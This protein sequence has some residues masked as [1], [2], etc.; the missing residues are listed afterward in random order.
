MPYRLL[1]VIVAIALILML[2]LGFWLSARLFI[3]RYGP[4][5]NAMAPDQVRRLTAWGFA[6]FGIGLIGVGIGG[7]V[8]ASLAFAYMGRQLAD[9]SWATGIVWGA[10]TS[11]LNAAIVGGLLVALVLNQ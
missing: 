2:L 3:N 8:L 10:V 1:V 5:D 7:P 4:Q 11:V 9:V 6:G